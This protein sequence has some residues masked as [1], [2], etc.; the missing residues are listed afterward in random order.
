MTDPWPAEELLA[1]KALALAAE[2]PRRLFISATRHLI[3]FAGVTLAGTSAA[4]V[5]AL[6]ESL[7]I[8]G[9]AGNRTARLLGSGAVVPC[10]VAATVNGTAAHYHDYDDDEP[11]VAIGHPSA[12][13]LAAALAVADATEC[14]GAQFLGAYLAGVETTMRIGAIVNPAHYN[15]GWHA[16][17]TLG[18]FG[19]TVAAGAIL[20][21]GVAEL[22]HA[23][24][25]AAS[26]SSG[27]KG[28]FGSDVKSFQAGSAAGNGL[29]A[30]ELAARGV[31]SSAGALFGPQ[32]FCGANAAQSNIDA[33]VRD[34]A[35][36]L[37]FEAP[38]LNI[39]LYPCCS[40]THTALDGLFEILR[41]HAIDRDDIAAVD[42]WIGAD[43]PQILIYD[44]PENGLQGKFS[45]RYCLAAAI[46]FGELTL[47]TFEDRQVRR[48]E[49]AALIAKIRVHIDET[50]PR[51]A[52]GVTHMSRIR[53]TTKSGH[54]VV[55]AIADPLG[56]P[57]RPLP[58]G[59]VEG[60]FIRC[61]SGPLGRAA[62]EKAFKTLKRTAESGSV[63]TIVGALCAG[64][65]RV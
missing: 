35:N 50:L 32:G 51:C 13:V 65:G 45:L 58:D 23:L 64:G 62:A 49:I 30:A 63:R 19:A 27:L 53:V 33:I 36:P 12:P 41:E 39:K 21:L 24:G 26:M 9:N 60:K 47:E 11:A 10:R 59:A 37:G 6:R 8:G 44:V 46:H 31:Q 48:P 5:R 4:L 57:A 18:V 16:T 2:P 42:V 61:A 28:N 43:V 3:D 14:T 29:W 1:A 20:G 52:T 17:A 7:E 54:D 25:I 55:R 22:R 40:S 34:F 56:S 15:A 38:G